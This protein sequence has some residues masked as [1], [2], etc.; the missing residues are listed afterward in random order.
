VGEAEGAGVVAGGVLGAAVAL[1]A[2]AVPCAAGVAVE[3]TA[4]AAD[5]TALVTGLA[6]GGVIAELDAPVVVADEGAGALG[7]GVLLGES[8]ALVAAVVP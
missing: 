2:A 8:V 1:V 6:E 7:G 4:E 3:V 5:V